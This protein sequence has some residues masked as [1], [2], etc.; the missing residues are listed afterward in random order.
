[1]TQ[2]LKAIIR[3][4][5]SD[6]DLHEFEEKYEKEKKEGFVSP[7]VT[8]EYGW[9][10]IRSPYKD[11][12]RKGV[13]LFENCCNANVDQRDFLFFISIGY[14]KLGEF[15]KSLRYVKRLL[16]IEPDNTQ[17][18]DLEKAIEEKMALHGMMGMALVGGAVALV[19]LFVTLVRR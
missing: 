14:Y 17:G 10:L 18:L 13:E 15:Q 19:G 11:D 6:S 1:M 5:I 7:S 9:C 8:F 3:D 2:N 4:Y 12:V 16:T